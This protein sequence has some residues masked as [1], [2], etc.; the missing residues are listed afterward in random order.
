MKIFNVVQK[1]PN[2]PYIFES[3]QSHVV[4]E[5]DEE[6]L[7]LM[8]DLNNSK[9]NGTIKDF[10]I[11]EVDMDQCTLSQISIGLSLKDYAKLLKYLISENKVIA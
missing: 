7:L 8:R 2:Q 5:N 10:I 1:Y 6:E 4:V 3:T 9:N 11:T